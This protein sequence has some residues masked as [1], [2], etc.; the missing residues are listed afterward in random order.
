MLRT[1]ISDFKA[2]GHSVTTA[3]DSRL[4]VLNPPVEA[5]SVLPVSSWKEA[6]AAVQKLAESSDATYVIAPESD[7][8][9]RSLLASLQGKNVQSLNCF[10]SAVGRVSDKAVFQDHVKRLGLPTPEC[11]VFSVHTDAEEIAQA[12]NEEIGFP[13]IFKPLSGVGCGGLSVV[14]SKRAV[15]SAVNK[16]IGESSGKNFMA[17]ELIYGVSASVSLISTGGEALPVSLNKQ[18]VSLGTPDS[19]STYDGGIVPFDSPQKDAAFS[20][21]KRVGEAFHGLRGYV[22]V[23]LVLS[24]EEPVVIELN[25]RLTTSYVGLRRVAG[26]NPAQAIVEA[27]LERKLPQ[28]DGSTGYAYFSKVKTAKPTDEA[29]QKSYKIREVVSPPYPVSDGG[30]AYALLSSHGATVQKAKM[31]FDEAKKRLLGMIGDGGK[32]RW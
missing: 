10:S 31:G 17:Q 28:N 19:V 11:L 13:A 9:L 32:R 3:L 18:N 7:D 30:E 25:P 12:V 29:L 21:A 16:I 23:D 24:E 20:A 4:S 27:V 26:F 6:Q 5:D 1:L 2:A 22:G 15:A 14:K 8:V